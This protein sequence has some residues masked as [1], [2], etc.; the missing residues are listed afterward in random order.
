MGIIYTNCP[1]DKYSFALSLTAGAPGSAQLCD[2]LHFLTRH[3]GADATPMGFGYP[4][5]VLTALNA[6]EPAENAPHI[7]G[8][9]VV[10]QIA[11]AHGGRA[12]FRQNTPC[13]AKTT[14][15]LPYPV[16]NI[17]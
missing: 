10:Q 3:A 17:L 12:V 15:W 7:L 11:A 6:A 14:V 2:K 5:A 4:S 9:Y 16:P 13:E 1:F 8:L